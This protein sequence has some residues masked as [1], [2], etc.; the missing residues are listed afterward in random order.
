MGRKTRHEQIESKA[1]ICLV[2]NSSMF[3][4][5][6]LGIGLIFAG[7]YL[8]LTNAAL[9]GAVIGV[10]EE[11]LLGLLGFLVFIVGGIF[12]LGK[13]L[14]P[15]SQLEVITIEEFTKRTE[16]KMT[17]ETI[18]VLDTSLIRAYRP[19][20]LESYL[21]KF[22]EVIVPDSVLEE[23]HQVEGEVGYGRAGELSNT[24]KYFRR[25]RE[26]VERNS[27]V[28][29]GFEEYREPAR[30][31]LEQTEKPTT[32]REL[33]PYVQKGKEKGLRNLTPEESDEIFNAIKKRGRVLKNLGM[34][35]VESLKR[36]D[37]CFE[38]LEDYLDKL[39][40]KEADVDVLAYAMHNAD[41]G[42]NVLVGESDIDLRQAVEIL[43][44]RDIKIGGLIDI[45]EPH[46]QEYLVAR[47]PSPSERLTPA[48][49]REPAYTS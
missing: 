10:G 29:E 18:L 46:K 37:N 16:R 35:D 41:M 20:E 42:Y 28:Q 22:E 8:I 48:R 19:E 36:L 49:K 12:L 11:N 2:L 45:V 3:F 23:L 43:Q 38:V 26:V 14:N 21:K 6:G 33:M 40:V 34:P 39:V 5:R 1:F 32:A 27:A 13:R 31:I 15:N 17:S 44:Y 25:L 24:G 47:K 30:K 7:I 9:T 4:K